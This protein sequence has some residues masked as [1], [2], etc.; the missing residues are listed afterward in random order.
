[1]FISYLFKSKDRGIYLFCCLV[2]YAVSLA[3]R[4]E[5]WGPYVG[6]LLT[7]H[8]FLAWLIGS[9]N[10]KSQRTYGIPATIAAHL[11]FLAVLIAARLGIMIAFAGMVHSPTDPASPQAIYLGLR[12]IRILLMLVGYG[13]GY[14]EYH[15]LLRRE[16]DQSAEQVAQAAPRPVLVASAPVTPFRPGSPLVAATGADHYEW[17]Q[18][19]GQQKVLYLDP[20]QSPKD[21]FEQWLRARGKTQYPF[22]QGGSA[23]IAE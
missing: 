14:G 1:M 20:R 12:V 5:V 10:E 6:L 4:P 21:E 16:K 18:Q 8:L 15:L 9:A 3:L 17:L 11:G 22:S 13:V 2:G 7:Y 23:A 19:R